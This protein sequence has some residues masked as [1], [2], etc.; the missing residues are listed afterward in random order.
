MARKSG[1]VMRGGRMRRQ[2]TWIALAPSQDTIAAS[3]TAV[4]ISQLDA[5]GLALRP[6]TVVRTRGMI[7]LHSDQRAAT[8]DYEVNYSHSVVTTQASA[9]GV[10]AVPTPVTDVG[11]DVPHVFESLFGGITVTTDVGVVDPFGI[12]LRFDSKAMRKVDDGQDLI[13]VVETSATSEGC[14]MT[15][16]FRVLVKL[17]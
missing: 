4:L 6:F 15:T 9:I 12:S 8:E 13:S 5:V 3:S 2:S 17:H 14:G 7:L 1:N 11:S 16:G 10:T